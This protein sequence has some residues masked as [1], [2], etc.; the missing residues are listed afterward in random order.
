MPHGRYLWGDAVACCYGCKSLLQ[1]SCFQAAE[2]SLTLLLPV[3]QHPKD[4]RCC[5]IDNICYDKIWQWLSPCYLK[6][7][8]RHSEQYLLCFLGAPFG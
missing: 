7:M 8:A 5:I 6:I 2:D 3:M 1:A 4:T